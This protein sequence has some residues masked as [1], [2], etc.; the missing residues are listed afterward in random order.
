MSFSYDIFYTDQIRI[1]VGFFDNAFAID[2]EDNPTNPENVSTAS[3]AV[4]YHLFNANN[5]NKGL[6]TGERTGLMMVQMLTDTRIK[7]EIFEDITSQNRE[8]TSN[9]IYYVR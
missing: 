5:A 3:G 8:F 4:A 2:N 9:A 6:P 7:L 1:G